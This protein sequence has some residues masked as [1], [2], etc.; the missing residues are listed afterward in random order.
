MR[1]LKGPV[2]VE[3][4]PGG[5]RR[6]LAS[7]PLGEKIA[8]DLSAAEAAGLVKQLKPKRAPRKSAAGK[9]KGK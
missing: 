2:T 4:R 8:F 7:S 1:I 6:L 5:A 9:S 3:E